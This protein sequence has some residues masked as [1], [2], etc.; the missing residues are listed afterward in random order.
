M[1]FDT[2]YSRSPE[3]FWGSLLITHLLGWR[4]LVRSAYLLRK[5]RHDDAKP[6]IAA[7][8]RKRSRPMSAAKARAHNSRRQRMIAINPVFWLSNR[9][10]GTRAFTWTI[11]LIAAGLFLTSVMRTVDASTGGID[12]IGM[13]LH[14]YGGLL[15]VFALKFAVASRAAFCF[16]EARRSG[17]M[18]LI[19]STPL[20]VPFI[21]R[22]Q[23]RALWPWIIWPSILIG[24]VQ[25]GVF[26]TNYLYLAQSQSS[27]PVI[28]SAWG[29]ISYQTYFAIMSIA[30]VVTFVFD[31]LALSWVGM[32][33]GLSAKSSTQAAVKSYIAVIL[34][35]ALALYF[36]QYC[37]FVMLQFSGSVGFAGLFVFPALVVVKD[38]L[39]LSWA[40]K[41]LLRDFRTIASQTAPAKSPW[42]RFKRLRSPAHA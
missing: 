38:L 1:A 29:S 21:L 5:Y 42:W 32:W 37:L 11:G 41:R 33:F 13:I 15:M 22:G 34:L 12:I 19:L 23:R 35:P 25:L 26:V 27:A 3:R 6:V 17:A 24:I 8:G 18:E 20:S 10:G 4:F 9:T 36:L 14:S 39:F 7:F 40:R 16:T 2:Y 30:G 31:V 28:S